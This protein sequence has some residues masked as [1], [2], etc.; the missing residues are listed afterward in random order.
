MWVFII[1]FAGDADHLQ[2][3]LRL[4]N[5][6][7]LSAFFMQANDLGN[8]FADAHDRV[9]RRHR[10]LKDHG[11]IFAADFAHLLFLQPQ[12]LA[13]LKPDFTAFHSRRRLRQNPQNSLCNRCFACARFTDET[14]GLALFKFK[15]NIVDRVDDL[16]LGGVFHG[17][18]AHGKQ[19]IL[20][21]FIHGV[22]LLNS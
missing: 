4:L 15:G 20:F 6:L 5:R 21:D 1:A 10:V 17:Q 3:F 12:Q 18:V 2:H 11:D 22:D 16:A 8:L 19:R 13:P 7:C 9:Q 14:D